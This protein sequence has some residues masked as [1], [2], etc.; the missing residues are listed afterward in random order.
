MK[1]AR[2]YRSEY[3]NYQGKPDQIKNRGKRNAARAKLM[4][5]GRVH[6]GDGLDVDHRQGVDKGNGEA[7]LRVKTKSANR[8][9]PRN[10]S[11]GKA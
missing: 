7:N 11:G 2:N 9:F 10:K 8:S 1:K 5:S 6:K 4:K 3:D